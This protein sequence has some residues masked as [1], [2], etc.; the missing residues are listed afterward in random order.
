MLEFLL[1]CLQVC[2][3]TQPYFMDN[4]H[5]KWDNLTKLERMDFLPMAV[6]MP[7]FKEALV[8]NR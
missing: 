5:I 2:H 1:E 7:V 3:T 8:I 4:N 6:S